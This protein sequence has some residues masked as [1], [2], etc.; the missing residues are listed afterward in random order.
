MTDALLKDLL[1]NARDPVEKLGCQDAQMKIHS[2]WFAEITARAAHFLKTGE[3]IV[4]LE[5][6]HYAMTRAL[7][8]AGCRRCGEMIRSGYDYDGFRRLGMPDELRWDGDPLRDLNE[9]GLVDDGS[10][11]RRSAVA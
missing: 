2:G 1:R 9:S 11:I 8:R 4:A 6:G 3:R 5:C 10:T 7:Y